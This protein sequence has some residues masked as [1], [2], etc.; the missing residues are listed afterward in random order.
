MRSCL[1]PGLMV[2]AV[3]GLT[4]P[5]YE[6]AEAP[7]MGLIMQVFWVAVKVFR[8]SSIIQICSKSCGI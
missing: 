1:G 7:E 3:R 2:L 5:G 6:V 4:V 8:V